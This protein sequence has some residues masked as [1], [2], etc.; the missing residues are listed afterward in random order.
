ME[1]KGERLGTWGGRKELGSGEAF[2][3]GILKIK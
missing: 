1:L 3:F 2:E